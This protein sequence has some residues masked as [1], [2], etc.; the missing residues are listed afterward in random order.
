MAIALSTYDI[1]TTHYFLRYNYETVGLHIF[2]TKEDHRGY[3]I[4]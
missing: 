1:P 4:L 2:L 3:G